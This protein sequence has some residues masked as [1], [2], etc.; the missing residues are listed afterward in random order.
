MATQLYTPVQNFIN[1]MQP[2]KG[3]ARNPLV[4][5]TYQAL[6]NQARKHQQSYGEVNIAELIEHLDSMAEHPDI[7]PQAAVI[8]KTQANDLQ[9]RLELRLEAEAIVELAEAERVSER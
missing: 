9:S 1:R 4:R 7:H 2:F 6:I 3:R 5:D 8:I